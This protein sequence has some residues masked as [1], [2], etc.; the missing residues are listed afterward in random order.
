MIVICRLF[1]KGAEQNGGLSNLPELKEFI[2]KRRR[3][4]EENK[5]S[6]LSKIIFYTRETE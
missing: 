6:V 2:L 1:C 3:E 4:V 5:L